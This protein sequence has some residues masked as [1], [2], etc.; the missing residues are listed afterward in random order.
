MRIARRAVSAKRPTTGL[1][2]PGDAEPVIGT[3]MD[4]RGEPRRIELNAEMDDADDVE[5]DV[6]ADAGGD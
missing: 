4:G 6:P 3:E 2:G 5:D 1:G